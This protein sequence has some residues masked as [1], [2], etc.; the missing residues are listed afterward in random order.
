MVSH[1]ASPLPQAGH[2]VTPGA[3]ADPHAV[4]FIDHPS[5]GHTIDDCSLVFRLFDSERVNANLETSPV[6]HRELETGGADRIASNPSA[7]GN[8]SEVVLDHVAMEIG[9]D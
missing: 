6:R 8:D 5:V 2:V 1:R 9:T 7:E 3:T 4:Q